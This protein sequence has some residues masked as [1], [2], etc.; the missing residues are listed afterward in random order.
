MSE[1]VAVS[2]AAYYDLLMRWN[3]AVNL[4]SL[5]DGDEALDRLVVEPLAASAWLPETGDLIDV[6]S[7]GGSPAIP[8][9]L[10]RAGLSLVMVE[11]R[12]RKAA[13]LREC[14]RHLQLDRV[15]VETAALQDCA[16]SLAS[17]A[18]V[19]TVR[20]VRLDAELL[21]A[22]T[23]VAAPRGELWFFGSAAEPVKGPAGWELK[24]ERALVVQRASALRVF[25]RSEN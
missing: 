16:G 17:R 14:A 10:A 25:V 21:Q 12:A 22:M 3:R 19:V 13:F 6:G 8:L 4:T 18:T 23:V 24:E 20:A 9:R 5:P 15:W 2:A 11:S 7:G 1:R